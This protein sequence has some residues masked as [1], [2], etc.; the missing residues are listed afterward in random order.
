M[1]WSIIVQTIHE[2]HKKKQVHLFITQEFY[3]KDVE[4]TFRM[5]K[6][7]FHIIANPCWQWNENIIPNILM[8]N[9]MLYNMIL[10]NKKVE[11]L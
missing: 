10:D 5:L 8:A 6:F 11:K 2:L 4:C 7:Y 1:H 3:R 9:M